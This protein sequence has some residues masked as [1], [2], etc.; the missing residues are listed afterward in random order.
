MLTW[1]GPAPLDGCWFR[2][3]RFPSSAIEKALT[4]PAPPDSLTAYRNLPLGWI[5]RNEGLVASAA[6]MGSESFPESRS[7]TLR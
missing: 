6:R 2:N 7:S 1:H 4:E 5:S 3:F